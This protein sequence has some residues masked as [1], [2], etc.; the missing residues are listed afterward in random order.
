MVVEVVAFRVSPRPLRDPEA[1][2]EDELPKIP[3]PNVRSSREAAVSY[4]RAGGHGQVARR[5]AA[6]L[7]EVSR[8]GDP[9]S[10]GRA[11]TGNLFGLWHDRVGDYRIV[12]DIEDEVLVILVI[13]VEHRSKV[14]RR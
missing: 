12:C 8:L 14:H 13:E 1:R 7:R 3:R 10:M 6:K 9:R 11:L 4:E 2:A 5:I